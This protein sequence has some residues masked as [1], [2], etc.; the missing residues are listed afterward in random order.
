M[1]ISPTQI[2]AVFADYDRPDSPG[3]VL[4]VIH[5]GQ[6]AYQRGYGMADL[7]RNVPL[8]PDSVFDIAST[9]K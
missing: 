4:A 8:S 1:K 3:C 6:I 9:G 5:E 7:E 2:D